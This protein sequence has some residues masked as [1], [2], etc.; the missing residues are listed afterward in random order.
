MKTCIK[1]YIHIINENKLFESNGSKVADVLILNEQSDY[2]TFEQMIDNYKS[3]IA[4]S[5]FTI[6]NPTENIV[7]LRAA[8]IA[9]KESES[10]IIPCIK[11][12]DDINIEAFAV[13]L[14][15]AGA[16][17]IG[18]AGDNFTGV[19]KWVRKVQN[20]CSLPIYA[21]IKE[22]L[23]SDEITKLVAL[24]ARIFSCD[25]PCEVEVPDLKVCDKVLLSSSTHVLEID[26]SNKT[27][28]IGER[29]NPT[30]KPKLAEAMKNMDIDYIKRRV[31]SQMNDGSSVID[32]NVGAAGVDEK[33]LLI[34]LATEL[35]TFKIPLCFD[36]FNTEAIE[37]ALRNYCGRAIINSA[38]AA[39]NDYEKIIDIA[40][41]YGAMLILLPYAH[42]MSLSCE[43]RIETLKPLLECAYKKGLTKSDIL[44]DGVIMAVANDVTAPNEAAKFVKWCTSQGLMT[45]GGVSN[46]SFGLPNR[47]AINREFLSM[48]INAGLTTGI[49]NPT[50]EN[51]EVIDACYL[52]S[53]KDEWCMGWINKNR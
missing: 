49:L 51:N 24:N 32:V 26:A 37:L 10:I 34:T 14:E 27:Y 43:D 50:K 16:D 19:Q 45:V 28:I 12:N 1:N 4:D 29:V 53:G 21:D 42:K 7:S 41:K 20:V 47:E 15:A 46:I 18:I 22:D 35:S 8:V 11:I 48:L 33:S 38:S 39:N 25:I 5:K 13:T 40:V 36:S 17:A 9:A 2:K 3:D 31:T 30:G 52:L 44:I 23:T 6:T